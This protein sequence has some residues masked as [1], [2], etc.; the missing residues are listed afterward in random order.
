MGGARGRAYATDGGIGG[1]EGDGEWRLM[2][3]AVKNVVEVMMAFLVLSSDNASSV[4][5]YTS[6]SSDLHGPSWGIPLID[7]DELLE[8]DPYEEV[9]QKGQAP[10]LSPA[11]V[12]DHMELDGHV[13]VYVPEPEHPE[14]HVPTDDD[15]HP[16]DDDD[17]DDDTND[18]E[19]EPTEDEEEEEQIPVVDRVPSARDT[20]AFET[21]E[22]APTP[23]SPQTILFSQIRLRKARKN[24]KVE[25][26]M[27]ASMEAR[28][29]E[30]AAALPPPPGHPMIRMRDDI[31]E[32]DMPPWRRFVFTTTP[33]GCDVAKSSTTTTRPPRV[34]DDQT[35]RKDIRLEIDV[36]RGIISATRDTGDSHKS[37]EVAAPERRGSCSQTY[38]VIMHVTRQGI[39]FVMT[40]ESIQAMIDHALQRN[41]TPTH[42]D[43]SQS[44]GGGFK[45]PVQPA[46]TLQKKLTD[47]YCLKGEIKKLE[48]EL[49]NLK[50]R[51][52]EVAAYTQ[53]FQELALMCTKFLA[54]E[55]KK[56]DNYI[57]GLPDN[58][59]G[60][61]MS[62]RP[63]TLNDAIELANDLMDQK[64]H[65]YAK[66]L[67]D[68]KR[69][70]D[71]SSRNNQKQ[72]PYKKQN[73]ARAYTACPGEK[74]AYTRN[75][76]LCTKC[77]YHHI[78]KCAPKCEKCKRYGHTTSDCQVKNSN[79]K[80]QKAGACYECGNTRH[81]MKNYPKL[82]NCGKGNRDGIAQGSA[83]ALGGRDTSPDSNFITGTFLLNNRYA[84]VLFDTGADRSFISTTFSALVDITP[85]TLENHYDVELDDDKI[86]G[87]NTIIRGCT[88]NFMN[89][90]FN[91][92][93]MP[94]PLG[95]FDIIIRMDWLTKYHGV[96]ICDERIVCVPFR[97]DMLIFQG[98][99]NN[100]REESRLNIIS[101]TKAQKYL[102]KGCDVF[103]AHITIKEAKD[104]SEGKPLEDVPI[105][106][107]FRKIFL[108]DLPNIPLARQV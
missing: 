18:K 4:V 95:S 43:E 22:S 1:D 105:V 89:Y 33:P 99:G 103:L 73:V 96:I 47:K 27:S 76:P 46:R 91:V 83:Y 58:I 14:Y 39:N 104:K 8:M 51:G 57:D 21:D 98:D 74:K 36:V 54:D 7:V 60:K 29:V 40:P 24:V 48:I 93:L 75:L 107:D 44:L 100:Q 85:T 25:P 6:I 45:R 84:S 61:V 31:P 106:R 68:N 87:I 62:A 56:I 88:L 23:R 50:V 12:P 28:I 32:E 49:W 19:E 78:R 86:I 79:N 101:C 97:R 34:H 30:H 13:P 64:L 80:N 92:D 94:V 102:S 66:R 3:T 38:D 17:E 53:C 65:T 69:K 63:K 72:Q 16:S 35:G 77:N 71:D 41:S 2:V 52:N 81:I 108:E 20:K 82:K 9:A 5:A 67:S 37:Y 90:P 59:H 55:T 70:I 42:D 10:P 11:Y 26:P 15:M